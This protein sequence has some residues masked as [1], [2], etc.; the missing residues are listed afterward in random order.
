MRLPRHQ[1]RSVYRVYSEEDYLDATEPFPDWEADAPVADVRSEDPRSAEV[2]AAT[3]AADA[4]ATDVASCKSP[5]T[6]AQTL[7]RFAV[8]AALAGA[9]VLVGGAIATAVLSRGSTVLRGDVQR[10]VSEPSAA[11]AQAPRAARSRV[12]GS[13][14]PKRRSA[15]PRGL[16]A[17]RRAKAHATSRARVASGPHSGATPVAA[18]LGASATAQPASAGAV[19]PVAVAAPIAAVPDA[20][21]A[22]ESAAARE[23]APSAQ[24]SAEIEFG[25]ER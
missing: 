22:P 25:F 4:R 7:R 18:D 10:V 17:A 23:F 13:S 24:L 3:P 6:S 2:P 12:R 5:A 9:V 20:A 11:T 15:H 14:V 1:P 16:V 19:A 21:I 8:G